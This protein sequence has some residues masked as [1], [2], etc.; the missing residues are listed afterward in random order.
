[1]PDKN[2]LHA[3]LNA[4]ADEKPQ[5][6][7]SGRDILY[8]LAAIIAV[9]IV[10][11]AFTGMCSYGKDSPENAPV[12]TVD[13]RTFFDLEARAMNFP[14]R[15][16]DV[17][18]DWVANSVR[19]GAIAGQPAPIVGW[20]IGKNGYLQLTQTNVPVTE[21]IENIDEHVREKTNS[22]EV[23]GHTVEV[24]SGTDH[25]TRDLRVVDLSDVRLI[26][27][28]AATDE[29]FNDLLTRT[30]NTAPIATQREAG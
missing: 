23:A 15:L 14:V 11:V 10:S 21:A 4:V 12:V 9:M 29:Q 16:P 8:S 13:A 22:Y 18:Q 26:V 3:I 6:F 25:D 30:I 5:I 2:L 19:R 17:P 7:Q 20:V 27:T 24:F 28:G 1:M